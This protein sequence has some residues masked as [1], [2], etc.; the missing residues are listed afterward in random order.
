MTPHNGLIQ[1]SD[2][3]GDNLN[4]T[5]GDD[6]PNQNGFS[7]ID[8]TGCKDT[9]GDGYSTHQMIGRCRWCRFLN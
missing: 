5:N 4:G 7:T 2:G 1:T 9:D 8:R 3:F 6:C